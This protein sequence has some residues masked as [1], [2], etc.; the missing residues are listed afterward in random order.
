VAAGNHVQLPDIWLAAA[1]LAPAPP[2]SARISSHAE[3]PT[4]Q[5]SKPHLLSQDVAQFLQIGNQR[6][7]KLGRV[8]T[9]KQKQQEN[10]N[11]ASQACAT[12][13]M[14]WTQVRTYVVGLQASR[15]LVLARTIYMY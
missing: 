1:F 6:L 11:V 14:R 15:R 9:L 3:Q 8:I 4:N 2:P 12:G 5:P 10:T 7:R 13:H